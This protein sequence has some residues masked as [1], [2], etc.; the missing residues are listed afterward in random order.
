MASLKKSIR[1]AGNGVFIGLCFIATV[2]AL[3]VLTVILWTLVVKGAGGVNL[4]VFTMS[5][6]ASGSEGGLLNAIVGSIIMCSIGM[7][8]AVLFGVLAGT[9]LAE[10]GR[11]HWYAETVRFVNDILLSAPSVLVGLVVFEFLVVPFHGASALAGSVA[12]ALVAVPI[13]TRTTEDVLKLQPS[14]LRESGVALGTPLWTT[15]RQV[16][17]KSAGAGILTGG[18]LAFARIS[19]ETA[20]LIFTAGGNQFFSLKLDHEMASLPT[21]I[22]NFALSA[23]DDLV[24]LAWTASLI[25][26]VAVLAANILARTITRE[27]RP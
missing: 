22:F 16:L 6:P 14:A 8:I 20:P 5:T 24:R 10:Y 23:Y 12:L 25:V 18:L 1:S 21:V 11:N 15:I 7:V 9:W 2:L 26:A 17:W 4:H 19:G 27:R 13:I 3:A